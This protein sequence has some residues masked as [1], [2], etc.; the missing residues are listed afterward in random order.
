MTVYVQVDDLESYLKKAESLGGKTVM[1]VT[2]IPGVVTLAMFS[3]P[4]GNVIGMVKE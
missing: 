3:D 1:P 4:E 2:E